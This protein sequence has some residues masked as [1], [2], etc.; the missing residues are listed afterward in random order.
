MAPPDLKQGVLKRRAYLRSGLPGDEEAESNDD[1]D[2]KAIED[3]QGSE[4]VE[5]IIRDSEEALLEVEGII[6]EEQRLMQGSSGA[7][8]VPN[9]TCYARAEYD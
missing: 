1:S 3:D 9:T 8:P 6:W 4:H 5:E 2:E 7:L